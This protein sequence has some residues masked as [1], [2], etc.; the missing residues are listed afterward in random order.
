ML[1]RIQG[2]D[3]EAYFIQDEWPKTMILTKA[4]YAHRAVVE[5]AGFIKFQ[6]LGRLHRDS[7]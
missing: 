7:H 5:Y 3:F 2:L 6:R 1:D 4:L